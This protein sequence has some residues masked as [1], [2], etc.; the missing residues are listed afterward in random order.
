MNAAVMDAFGGPAVL[1]FRSVREP[2][3]GPGDVLVEVRAVSVN[4]TLDC[5]VRAGRYHVRPPLPHVLGND[6]AGIVAA[7]GRDVAN[8]AVGERVTVRGQ[9]GPCGRCAAC[10][11]R[12]PTECSSVGILGVT[13]WGGYADYVS[14]PAR[15]VNAIPARVS[16]A[17]ACV[18]NRHHSAAFHFLQGLAQL[19]GGEWVLVM[20]AAG[21]L[22]SALVQV[23]KLTGATV[24][25]AAG[26]DERVASCLA[27]GA[28]FGVNY[29][30]RDLAAEVLRITDGR[31]VDVVAEN[32]G[33]PVLWKGAFFSLA[34]DGRLVT[35]GAHGGGIVEI[36]VSRL[37]AYR[38]RILGGTSGGPEYAERARKAAEAG[39]IHAIIGRVLPLAEAAEAHRIAE[40]Q[41]VIGKVILAPKDDPRRE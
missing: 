16:I 35:G 15:N 29:R 21:A 18:I 6:P 28:D 5:A 37:Y 26:T 7:V 22:G 25:A 34:R 33:D 41:E 17:D 8:V 23:A 1:T 39:Q 11:G 40:A 31:G 32:I 2:E 3:P 20:G 36:D 27:N 38:L 13:V 24:I 4:R 19:Q 14:V 10:L 12:K 30:A 9:L